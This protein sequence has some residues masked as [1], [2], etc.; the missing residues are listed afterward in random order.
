MPTRPDPTP[1]G[2]APRMLEEAAERLAD[3]VAQEKLL[4]HEKDDLCS[5]EEDEEP[6]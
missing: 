1:A 2:T 6:G 5:W 4:G 3:L